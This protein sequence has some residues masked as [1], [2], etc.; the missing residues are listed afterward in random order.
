M[1]ILM[2]NDHKRS[3]GARI[4][5]TISLCVLLL[6]AG[7]V[8]FYKLAFPTYAHR[9]R[10]SI[11]VEVNGERYAGSSQRSPDGAE[12]NPGPPFQQTRSQAN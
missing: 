9:Y 5:S 4:F 3:G 2:P 7:A 12:R 8:A 11:V 10:L 6:A 1:K